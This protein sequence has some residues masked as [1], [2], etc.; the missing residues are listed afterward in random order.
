MDPKPSQA[1]TTEVYSLRPAPSAWY[2]FD[3]HLQEVLLA[4]Q[5]GQTPAPAITL[6]RGGKL[7]VDVLA[8][9]A[10][11]ESPIDGFNVVSRIGNIATGW[12]EVARI[13]EVRT[14]VLSLKAATEMY[15]N[16]Y[17]S[18]PEIEC[19]ADTLRSSF[20]PWGFNGSG[21]VVGV[22]D[23]DCDFM[24]ENFRTE[25]G[26]RILYLW[27]QR[28]DRPPA[29]PPP[30]AYGYG[31]EFSKSDID[32]ALTA[33]DPY[34]ALRYR[35][36]P[37]AHG[38][39]VLD[40][41]AGNGRASHLPDGQPDTSRYSASKAPPGVAPG[42]SLIF[43]HLAEADD[44]LGNSRQLLEAVSY[45]FAKAEEL[46]MPAVVNVSLSTTGG[47]HDGKTLVE[48]GFEK[49]LESPGRM[50]VMAAGNAYQMRGHAMETAT[51]AAPVTLKWRTDPQALK[52]EAEVWY[53]GEIPLSVTLVSPDGVRLG[54][55]ALGTTSDLWQGDKRRGRISHRR[56]DPNDGA[57]QIDIRVPAPPLG[58]VETWEIELSAV[59]GNVSLHA[60]I[61]QRD[62]GDAHFLNASSSS[63][64]LGSICCG[65]S[66][67]TV[68]AYRTDL[69]RV[70]RPLW[71]DS[72]AG[73]T[74]DGRTDKPEVS[75][76]GASI[77]AARSTGGTTTM[78]GTSMAA[79]H[80]AGL[81]ALLFQAAKGAGAV[82]SS[83]QIR[84]AI[85]TTARRDPPAGRRSKDPRYGAGRISGLA[86]LRFLRQP[87]GPPGERAATRSTFPEV[88]T[89]L[90][91]A[92][93][94]LAAAGSAGGTVKERHG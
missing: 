21:V 44:T 78:S 16:M 25:Q 67:L 58:Q 36:E 83:K 93:S 49:L 32:Q 91:G 15:V 73:P 45:I 23:F 81:A 56:S 31:R 80:A 51:P 18:V 9:V 52:N 14:K 90:P 3:P 39:H 1:L 87:A 74:R 89:G 84:D 63:H 33:P 77:I 29:A 28:E 59:G 92:T 20:A 6:Q 50:I 61:E 40:I 43:V 24:H 85:V 79:P 13:P 68:G 27:D 5:A 48:L 35:P 26:T 17:D 37:G 34:G 10:D 30:A 19:Q 57:H 65:P 71:P 11:S 46:K 66:T 60:W 69:G 41:A 88:A 72:S 38:T 8:H 53:E 94:P 70:T 54:P 86:A 82:A 12:V 55:V 42:A 64:T 22:V 76:P 2:D 75:A 62:Q 4:Q 47:P 7:T